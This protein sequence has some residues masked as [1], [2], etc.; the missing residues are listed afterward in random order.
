[1]RKDEAGILGSVAM[2]MR[3]TFS[4]RKV[5]IDILKELQRRDGLTDVTPVWCYVIHVVRP[6][7][8][9]NSTDEALRS[10]PEADGASTYVPGLEHTSRHRA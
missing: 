2:S 9:V 3:V 6:D 5:R 10:Y 7:N 8:T 4:E 1:M